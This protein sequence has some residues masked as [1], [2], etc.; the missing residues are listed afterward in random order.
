MVNRDTGRRRVAGVGPVIL[1]AG[2]EFAVAQHVKSRRPVVIAAVAVVVVIGLVVLLIALVGGGGG[3]GA[4]GGT[5]G[6]GY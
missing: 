5:G 6:F 4:G 2:R 3:G 1:G